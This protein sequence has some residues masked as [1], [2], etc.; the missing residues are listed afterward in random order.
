MFVK[1]TGVNMNGVFENWRES[2]ENTLLDCYAVKMEE[3]VYS[4]YAVNTT[5]RLLLSLVFYVQFKKSAYHLKDLLGGQ[6][7][8]E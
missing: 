3:L 2:T 8:L 5:N 4:L 1:K 6:T 7:Q